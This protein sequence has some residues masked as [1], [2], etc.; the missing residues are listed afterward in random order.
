MIAFPNYKTPPQESRPLH[1][2]W[3]ICGEPK[4]SGTALSKGGSVETGVWQC[5]PGTFNYFYDVDEVITI[6]SG[7]ASIREHGQIEWM[8]IRAGSVVH[9]QKGAAAVWK[10]QETISKFYVIVSTRRRSL[11]RRVLDRV[12]R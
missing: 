9:F 10:I 12:T 3:I 5:T 6:I 11:L 4:A 1:P 2:D 8:E 7:L